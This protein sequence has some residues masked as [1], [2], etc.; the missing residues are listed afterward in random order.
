MN[1]SVEFISPHPILQCFYTCEILHLSTH[2]KMTM[3][4]NVAQHSLVDINRR[5]RGA[6]RLQNHGDHSITHHPDDGQMISKLT[7]GDAAF[8]FHCSSEQKYNRSTAGRRLVSPDFCEQT[9]CLLTY[10]LCVSRQST[11]IS[12]FFS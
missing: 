6:Y 1:N 12:Y 9:Q 3:F 4:W 5:F 2:A 7:A 8:R 11:N 10:G